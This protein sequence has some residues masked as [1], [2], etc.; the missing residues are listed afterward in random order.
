MDDPMCNGAQGDNITALTARLSKLAEPDKSHQIW[1]VSYKIWD[2]ERYS[3]P[4]GEIHIGRITSWFK[5]NTNKLYL[6]A[7]RLK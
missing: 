3:L 2:G 7:V 1:S 6:D 4:I 5:R